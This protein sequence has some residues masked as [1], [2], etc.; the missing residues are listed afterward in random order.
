[1]LQ[2]VEKQS[3]TLAVSLKIAETLSLRKRKHMNKSQTLNRKKLLLTT[4]SLL[5][6]YVSLFPK[7]QAATLYSLTT[8]SLPSATENFAKINQQFLVSNLLTIDAIAPGSLSAS[9]TSEESKKWFEM[10]LAPSQ[11]NSVTRTALSFDRVVNSLK[12]IELTF[13]PDQAPEVKT[14]PQVGFSDVYEG[15]Y[16]FTPLYSRKTSVDRLVGDYLAFDAGSVSSNELPKSYFYNKSSISIG[17]ARPMTSGNPDD[18]E[19]TNFLSKAQ[20]SI[21]FP[22][23][24]EGLKLNRTKP[25]EQQLDSTLQLWPRNPLSMAVKAYGADGQENLAY[26]NEF[27]KLAVSVN[28]PLV[29]RAILVNPL[30]LQVD[31]VNGGTYSDQLRESTQQITEQNRQSQEAFQSR[32][33]SQQAAF[34]TQ[35]QQYQSQLQTQM[36][37]SFQS[38]YQQRNQQV[39]GLS[40]YQSSNSSLSLT[41]KSLPLVPRTVSSSRTVNPSNES[42]PNSVSNPVKRTD[43]GRPSR[44]SNSSLTKK[45]LVPRTN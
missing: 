15:I 28:L 10:T 35:Q 29:P 8:K 22:E 7:T 43:L 21:T 36:S 1:M 44:G 31:W 9:L 16:E 30:D 40:R 17:I 38:A 32:I 34:S 41:P 20:G 2:C 4:V 5:M 14:L 33:E 26:L 3:Q 11:T 27:G 19:I 39:P 42:T 24:Q 45:P 25:E 6:S 12:Q 37:Q 18:Q 13:N 23:V